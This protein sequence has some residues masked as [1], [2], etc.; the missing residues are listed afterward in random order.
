MSSWPSTPAE[1]VPPHFHGCPKHR[2]MYPCPKTTARCLLP[3]RTI[4]ECPLEAQEEAE[5][6]ARGRRF[7]A[8][9][10]RSG[11]V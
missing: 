10:T 4:A 7:W 9:L 2:S 1:R 6:V 8:P 11:D 3:F 5:K